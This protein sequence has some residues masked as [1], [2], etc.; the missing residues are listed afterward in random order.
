MNQNTLWF[1][2]LLWLLICSV[3][4]IWVG[5]QTA[6]AFDP[7]LKL[8]QAAMDTN[9]ESQLLDRLK[10]FS[11]LAYQTKQPEGYIFHI[12]QGDCF[13]ELLAKPHQQ[14]LDQWG[15]DNNFATI[16]INV[17]DIDP[18]KEIIPSTPTVIAFD[19]QKNLI[20]FGPYSRGKGCFST[21]GMIDEQ[22]A[23]W[24]SSRDQNQLTSTPQDSHS[25]HSIIETEAD[26]CYCQV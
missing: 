14:S 18:Y 19:E 12:A 2:V 11:D 25:L 10:E 6:K 13:C 20:Y 16:S 17:E 9:F 4:I 15:I 21:S 5:T 26:G 7:E 1:I 8:N 23:L 22:L 24:L 3:L